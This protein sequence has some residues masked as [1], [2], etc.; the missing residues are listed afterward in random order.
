VTSR[1]RVVRAVAENGAVALV[2]FLLVLLVWRVTH[3]TGGAAAEFAKG[4]R[5]T[6][7]GFSLKRLKGSGVVDL[8]AYAGRVVV[9]NFWASWCGPC[10]QEAPA[11]ERA[12]RRWHAHIVSFVGI[13][14]HDFT[15]DARLLVNRYHISYPTAH[16]G[17]ESTLELYG[18]NALPE[19]FIISPQGLVVDHLDGFAGEEELDRRI[20]RALRSAGAA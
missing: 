15:K 17:S 20:A 18:V 10:K 9:V 1:S 16:D 8:R 13:D 11:F 4:K 2:A 14:V 12:W 3:Q 6:A 19:T 7:P 5:P